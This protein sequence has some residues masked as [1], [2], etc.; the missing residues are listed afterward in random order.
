VPPACTGALYE[1]ELYLVCGDLGG[2][3]AGVYHFS[4]GDFGLRKLRGGDYRGVLVEATAGEPAIA[5]APLIIVCT[6][7]YWRNAWKYQ[8]HLSPFRLGQWHG[9]GKSF[10]C[11][12]RFGS[13]CKRGMRL[14]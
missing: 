2:L 13:A 8:A 5:H 12:D 11:R 6:C 10:G 4:P 7:I 14:R 1:V 9:F 3:E